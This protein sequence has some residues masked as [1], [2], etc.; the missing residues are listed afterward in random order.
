[1]KIIEF[2]C[3]RLT[4]NAERLLKACLD[5]NVKAPAGAATRDVRA[6]SAFIIVFLRICATSVSV[7]S[8]RSCFFFEFWYGAKIRV[9]CLILVKTLYFLFQLI[10]VVLVSAAGGMSIMF[11]R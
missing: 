5:G 4:F 6:M 8:H 2:S 7:S 1:M 10:V 3:A 9:Q 11:A